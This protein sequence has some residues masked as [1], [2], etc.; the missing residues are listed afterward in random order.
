MVIRVLQGEISSRDVLSQG[1]PIRIL[2]EGGGSDHC[3]K[4]YDLVLYI[5]YKGIKQML[6]DPCRSRG[7]AK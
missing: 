7:L 5:S 1:T 3:A 2:D 4:L 6:D